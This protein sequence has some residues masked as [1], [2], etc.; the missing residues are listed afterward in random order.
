MLTHV[1]S[2]S[3]GAHWLGRAGEHRQDVAEMRRRWRHILGADPAHNPNLALNW[4]EPW[5]PA[6]PPRVPY[7]WR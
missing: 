1:E 4:R 7:P 3:F 6:F 5:R 2:A